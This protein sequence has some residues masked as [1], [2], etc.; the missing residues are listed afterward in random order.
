MFRGVR[1]VGGIPQRTLTLNLR[2]LERDGLVTR[3]V[4]SNVPP[5]V[6]Y[7]LTPLGSSLWEPVRALGSWAAAQRPEIARARQA[8]DRAKGEC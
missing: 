4:T 8:F 3:T 6:D 7:D 1:L 2:G 5:R